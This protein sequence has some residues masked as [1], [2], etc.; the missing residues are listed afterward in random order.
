M[1]LRLGSQDVPMILTQHQV[2]IPT[3]QGGGRGDSPYQHSW[4]QSTK[5]SQLRINGVPTK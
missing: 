2:Y 5:H 3:Q 1:E 4:F